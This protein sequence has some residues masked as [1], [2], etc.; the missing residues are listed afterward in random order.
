MELF[1]ED[2]TYLAGGLGILGVGFLIAL[3]VTQQG[4]Y[5]IWALSALGLAGAVL[6]IEHFWVTDAERI[7]RVVYDLRDAVMASDAEQLLTHLTPDVEFV[8]QGRTTSSGEA[9]RA[10]IRS[11]LSG[12]K[13]DFVRITHLKAEASRLSR[14][15]SAEFRI[16]ASGSMQSSMVTNNFGTTNSDWS[17]GFEESS[18][19]VWKVNRISP[20]HAPHEL[21]R[22]EGSSDSR[23]SGE[24]H[25][26]GRSRLN[27]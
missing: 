6:V 13:F 9:T 14:L 8:Q 21:P 20:T 10:Y 16:I 18:P 5:L 7:E 12:T 23:P 24:R 2:P 25:R 22:P 17:L 19:G 3:R 27:Y 11:V 4:R 15:G 1:V 26:R